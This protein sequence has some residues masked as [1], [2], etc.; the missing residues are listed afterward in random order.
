MDNKGKIY[1]LAQLENAQDKVQWLLNYTMWTQGDLAFEMGVSPATVTQLKQKKQRM[2]G[3]HRA[4][5][6]Y[7]LL[8]HLDGLTEYSIGFAADRQYQQNLA[9]QKSK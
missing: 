4:L 5:L 8:K 1:R 3:Q 6:K 7:A 9:A 2:T